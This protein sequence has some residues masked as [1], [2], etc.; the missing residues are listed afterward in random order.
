MNTWG[1]YNNCAETLSYINQLPSASILAWS[2]INDQPDIRIKPIASNGYLLNLPTST[3]LTFNKT[4]V[5]LYMNG[6]G[7]VVLVDWSLIICI[8]HI[9]HQGNQGAQTKYQIIK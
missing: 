2:N 4:I 7:P 5:G 6:P 8:A 9:H 1:R 3:G